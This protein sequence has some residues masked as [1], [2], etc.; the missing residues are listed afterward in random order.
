MSPGRA[1]YLDIVAG[2][3]I[4]LIMLGHL[5]VLPECMLIFFQFKMS[6]FFFKSGM[7]YHPYDKNAR[8]KK[9][10]ELCRNLFI[11]YLVWTVFGLLCGIIIELMLEK[12]VLAA[13]R[14]ALVELRSQGYTWVNV[15][16][17]FF[18]GLFIVRGLSLFVKEK[19]F[20]WIFVLATC[21][22]YLQHSVFASKFGYVGYSSLGMMMYILGYWLRTLQFKKY[23][24]VVCGVVYVGGYI[25]APT[26]LDFRTNSTY[27]GSWTLAIAACLLAVIATNSLFK[28][29]SSNRRCL[30]VITWFGKN[31]MLLIV[32]HW[33]LKCLVNVGIGLTPLRLLLSEQ[34]FCVVVAVVAFTIPVICCLWIDRHPCLWWMI[35]RKN[36]S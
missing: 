3:F 29:M 36:V 12:P 2:I 11:P 31:A 28:R 27:V 16:L 15:P 1:H 8:M 21:L 35:G 24:G 33:P 32:M 34:Q 22:A 26:F 5:D 20:I 18:L 9:V 10:K 23:V 4:I 6:W 30:P 14:Y 17:W 25:V 7:F 19:Y 13:M